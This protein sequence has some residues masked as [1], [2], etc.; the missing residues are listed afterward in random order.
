MKNDI[1][2]I[3]FVISLFCCNSITAQLNLKF[4][5]PKTPEVYSLE[6][7]GNIPVSEYTGVPNIAIPLYTI[8]N[9]DIEIPLRLSYHSNGIRVDEEASWVGLGWNINL[10]VISQITKGWDD[11]V[12][13]VKVPNYYNEYRPEYI[14]QP[15]PQAYYTYPYGSVTGNDR[16]QFETVNPLYHIDDYYAAKVRTDGGISG[17]LGPYYP[18]GFMLVD[19]RQTLT[20]GTYSQVDIEVDL[21]SAN[22]F[23]HSLTFFIDPNYRG[24]KR[25]N[26]LNK[27]GYQIAVNDN[28]NDTFEWVVTAPDGMRYVFSEQ[29]KINPIANPHAGN[30]STAFEQENSGY[31]PFFKTTTSNFSDSPK[32]SS[33]VWKITKIIDTK[34]NEVYFHYEKL[35][36][37]ITYSGYSGHCDFLNVT[38]KG[39]D[40]WQTAAPGQFVGPDQTY[41]QNSSTL[42][43]RGHYSEGIQIKANRYYSNRSQQKSILKEITFKNAKIIFNRSNRLDLPGDQ[44]LD[45]M[46]VFYE[47]Q[48]I[49]TI[50][51]YF[52][53][54][55]SITGTDH[56]SKRLKLDGLQIKDQ[57]YNF[58]YNS[59]KLPRKNSLSQDYWG[60]YN[61]LTNNSMFYNPFR[62][63]RDESLI[64]T[65]A[66]ILRTEIE[67]Q[68][69]KSSHPE[70]I[71]AGILEMIQYPT[72][73][74]TK[75]VYELNEFDNYIFPNYDNKIN[76]VSYTQTK[77]QGFGLRIKTVTDSISPSQ[78][79]IKQYTYGG[80]KHITP[81]KLYDDKERY[82]S[83]Y[84][85]HG[86]GATWYRSYSRGDKITTYATNVYQ[87]DPLA[88]GNYVGYDKVSVEEINATSGVSNGKTI[89]HFTNIPDKSIQ[90]KINTVGTVSNTDLDLYANS[91][92]T[93]DLD[94]GLLIKKEIYGQDGSLRKEIVNSY[95]SKTHIPSLSYGVKPVSLPGKYSSLDIGTTSSLLRE[96]SE[97]LFFYYPLKGR[98]SVLSYSTTTD[99]FGAD[100]VQ[101]RRNYDYNNNNLVINDEIFKSSDGKIF[102]T[103][104]TYPRLE[105][106]LG[107]QNRIGIPTRIDKTHGGKTVETN[108]SIYKKFP[109]N[110]NLILLDEEISCTQV[111]YPDPYR[112][113]A[114]RRIS[115]DKYDDQGNI[116]EYHIEDGNSVTIV[117]SYNKMYP[118]AKIENATFQEVANALSITETALQDFDES[119]LNTLD[120]L[121]TTLSDAMV[122]T[123]VYDP[124]IG[125]KSIT[126][127]RGY[128]MHY[129]Y[130]VNNR[131][132]FVKDAEGHLISENKYHYKNQQ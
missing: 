62:L 37:I 30:Q 104:Y 21:F 101:T 74:F 44:R 41:N 43:S 49:K 35:Q 79:Y 69:N 113:N 80:G 118:V 85:R 25:I 71:K 130:D 23:G 124:L 54:F 28:G 14:V 53:Y 114:C 45:K 55:Q 87:N 108:R 63:Y 47:T 27:K 10:G 99:H 89:S 103:K 5:E 57:R 105:S 68:V 72:G 29:L 76:G 24:G 48:K 11:L 60:Y 93:A 66:I 64:P 51:F 34:G 3:L 65:W 8:K 129:T 97:Y 128:T 26:V 131:L 31:D 122:T 121:R 98:E 82:N 123:Y 59:I 9:G 19:Y 112:D 91:V 12:V 111:N 70:N 18:S 116:L 20:Y 102:S 46:E 58:S 2:I 88:N 7:Y 40:I 86:H 32:N 125:I 33:R 77:S 117:W 56:L 22:F 115:Y 50:D 90:Q 109:E 110:N 100:N 73:A 75:F 42:V 83:A 127:P 84:L 38:Q 17:Y 132:Q 107:S 95:T 36:S 94:N 6:K 126:D 81:F 67:N 119:S 120:N 52:S 78:K 15:Q 61:G 106:D 96:F 39:S 13:P 4:Q 16:I 1:T 92:R